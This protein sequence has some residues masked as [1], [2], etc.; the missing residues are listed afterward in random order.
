[1]AFD[2]LL[3][4]GQRTLHN[5]HDDGDTRLKPAGTRSVFYRSGRLQ[6]G[7]R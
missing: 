2:R 6:A 5:K 3:H 7:R 1:M 4:A